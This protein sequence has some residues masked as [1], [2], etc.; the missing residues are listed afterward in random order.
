MLV[1]RTDLPK[2]CHF[3]PGDVVQLPNGENGELTDE[4]YL[5]CFLPKP[6]NHRQRRKQAVATG[7]GLYGFDAGELFIVNLETGEARGMPH[8]SSRVCVRRDV[9]LEVHVEGGAA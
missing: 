8:L 1:V 4:L 9:V 7:F 5:I 3:K 2:L 6:T